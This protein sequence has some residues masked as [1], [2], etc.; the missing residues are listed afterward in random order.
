[1]GDWRYWKTAEAVFKYMAVVAEVKRRVLFDCYLE[2]DRKERERNETKP[3]GKNKV[4]PLGK[5]V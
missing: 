3:R 5:C 1:M 2:T 4:V